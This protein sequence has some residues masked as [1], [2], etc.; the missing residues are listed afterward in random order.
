MLM[1]YARLRFTW[2]VGKHYQQKK[3]TPFGAAFGLDSDLRSYNWA[4]S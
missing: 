1:R 4:S 2:I 3:A